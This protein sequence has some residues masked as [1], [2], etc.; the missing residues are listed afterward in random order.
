MEINTE[1]IKQEMFKYVMDGE[2]ICPECAVSVGFYEL[3]CC[4]C[5][6]VNVETY[7]DKYEVE[8][9]CWDLNMYDFDVFEK[10][11]EGRR[12]E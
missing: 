2:E 5:D 12:G 9:F 4:G 11:F 8:V 6:F 3:S 10:L 1:E 7:L